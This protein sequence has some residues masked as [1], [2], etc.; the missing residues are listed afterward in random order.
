LTTQIAFAGAARSSAAMV[1][2]AILAI[3]P[4]STDM[5]R[6]ISI[7]N[8][9]RSRCRGGSPSRACLAFIS[10]LNRREPLNSMPC[11]ARLM[12]NLRRVH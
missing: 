6:A 8:I 12:A 4:S 11:R 1:G 5:A 9:A 2:S 10:S 3:I 7:T